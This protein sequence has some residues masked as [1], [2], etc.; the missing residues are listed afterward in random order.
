MLVACLLAHVLLGGPVPE[1]GENG[2]GE[3]LGRGEVWVGRV[4]TPQTTVLEQKLKFSSKMKKSFTHKIVF[5]CQRKSTAH[6][7]AEQAEQAIFNKISASNAAAM[8]HS[9]QKVGEVSLSVA[10]F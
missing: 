8:S 3:R 10:V 6:K 5:S 1:L 4:Y 2:E 9:Q 7:I